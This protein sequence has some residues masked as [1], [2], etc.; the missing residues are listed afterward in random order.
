MVV[1][2]K[3][4]AVDVFLAATDYQR[5]AYNRR[6]RHDYDGIGVTICSPEDL[7][8]HK[9][10][11]HRLRDRSDI[12]DLLLVSGRLD[13]AYLRRWAEHLGVTQRLD[14]AL[15]DAGRGD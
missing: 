9:L 5:E 10:V 13:G 1:D 14:E 7:L 11:A 2:D 4:V 15:R 6:A 8:L 3:S 12:A